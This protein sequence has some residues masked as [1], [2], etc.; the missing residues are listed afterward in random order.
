MEGKTLLELR[1]N[2]HNFRSS[3]KFSMNFYRFKLDLTR[4]KLTDIPDTK[5]NYFI[6]LNPRKDYDWHM[7]IYFKIFLLEFKFAQLYNSFEH[8]WKLWKGLRPT[9]RIQQQPSWTGPARPSCIV[10]HVAHGPRHSAL[11]RDLR[12]E[13][14]RRR[15]RRW[16]HRQ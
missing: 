15:H 3:I 14:V 9:N 7:E 13:C 5:Y 1:N 6:F 2:F 12:S 4:L 10:V 8:I 11:S 16:L